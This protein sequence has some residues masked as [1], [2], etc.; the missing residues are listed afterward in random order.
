[1]ACVP[2]NHTCLVVQNYPM[3]LFCSENLAGDKLSFSWQNYLVAS[4]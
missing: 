2:I 3:A 1:M 4:S